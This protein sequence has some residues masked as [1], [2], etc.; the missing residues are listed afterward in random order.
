MEPSLGKECAE[1]IYWDDNEIKS[2]IYLEIGSDR[3][4]CGLPEEWGKSV[5]P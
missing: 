4:C 3:P 5:S 1:G 2:V